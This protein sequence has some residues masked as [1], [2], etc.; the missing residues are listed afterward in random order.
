[1][2]EIKEN[3]R[4]VK[5]TDE[6][7]DVYSTKMGMYI[8]NNISPQDLIHK[9][10][11][12]AEY[13]VKVEMIKQML[14]FPDGYFDENGNI[15]YNHKGTKMFNSWYRKIYLYMES[16]DNYRYLIDKKLTALLGNKS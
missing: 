8:L 12:E 3:Y 13:I 11:N 5:K 14:S 6:K 10:A 9:L 2:Y 16:V 15:D 4:I 7:Y 1:M